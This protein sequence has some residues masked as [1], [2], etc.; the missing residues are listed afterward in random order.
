MLARTV[1]H[2]FLLA[3][4][5]LQVAGCMCH[6]FDEATLQASMEQKVMKHRAA[7]PCTAQGTLCMLNIMH[8]QNHPPLQI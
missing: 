8:K 4:S 2:P 3:I 5:S 6:G 7:S 1:S